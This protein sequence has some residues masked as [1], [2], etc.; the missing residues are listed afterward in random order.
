MSG[1][2]LVDTRGGNELRYLVRPNMTIG[3][4]RCDVKLDEKGVDRRHAVIEHFSSG[5]AI[6]DL[7]SRAGVVVNGERIT[8]EWMLSAGDRVAIGP[9]TLRIDA[10]APA[11]AAPE[12]EEHHAAAT[13]PPPEPVPP[14]VQER[15]TG[16]R[17]RPPEFPIVRGRRR[18]SVATSGRATAFCFMV[19]VA[20]AVALGFYLSG[21]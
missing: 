21:T 10:A 19:L 20:D 7:G 12:H 2:V 5:Y 11:A 14:A 1:L 17:E 8:S 13:P 4:R 6:R 15:T 18:K 16:P 3:R 9:V